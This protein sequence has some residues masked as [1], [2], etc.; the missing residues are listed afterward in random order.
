MGN[1]I[2]APEPRVMVTVLGVTVDHVRVFDARRSASETDLVRVEF[3]DVHVAGE[4]HTMQQVVERV[5]Q[6]LQQVAD[7]RNGRGPE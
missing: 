6:A 2:A 7:G 3:G 4:L 1:G 5:A